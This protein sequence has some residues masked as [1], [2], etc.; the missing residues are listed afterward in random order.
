MNIENDRPPQQAAA[1][2]KPALTK[3]QIKANA[4]ADGLAVQTKWK[5]LVVEANALWPK[6]AVEDLA[7]AQGNF[8]RVAGMVQL[9]YRL[10]RQEADRQVTAFFGKHSLA[11]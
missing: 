10:D 7:K 11:A 9:A 8:H 2:P 4:L 5:G 1:P 3:N 6:L